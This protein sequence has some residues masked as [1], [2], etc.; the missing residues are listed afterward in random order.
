MPKTDGYVRHRVFVDVLDAELWVAED[1][2]G[3][4]YFPVRPT[5]VILDTDSGKALE[6]IKGD[7]RLN[8]S[9]CEIL[10]PTPGGMQTLQHLAS[11]EYA[12]WLATYDPRRMR[13]GEARDRMIERQ[14]T[15]MGLAQEIMLK[16]RELLHLPERGEQDNGGLEV[17]GDLEAKFRCLKCG[18]PHIICITKSGWR[19]QLGVQ[20]EV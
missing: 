14:R 9:L 1:A 4:L 19:L 13:E 8:Y 17:I 10:S 6:R 5:C 3:E 16:S 20:V 18:A 7:S 11:R 2:S 15:L 12:W